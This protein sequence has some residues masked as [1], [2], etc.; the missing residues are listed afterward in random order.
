[1]LTGPQNMP[2]FG[3]NELTP[4]EKRELITYI[5]MQ[6]QQEKDPG[7]LFNLGRLRPGHR[8][9][10]DLRRRHHHPG[11]RGAVDCGEVMTVVKD[12]AHDSGTQPVDVHD[13]RLSRF[14]IVQEG[15]RRDDIEIVTYESQF[16]RRTPRR[17]SGWSAPSPCC[18]CSPAPV[19]WRS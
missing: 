14:E 8:G 17:R 3:D 7:G 16:P 19:R 2:V 1:M 6:I 15:A 10:G 11:L 12:G 9:S 13:P 18:S 4:D 5:T